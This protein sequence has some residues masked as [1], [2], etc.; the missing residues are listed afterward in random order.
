MSVKLGLLLINCCC[1]FS[2]DFLI[3]KLLL[4]SVLFTKKSVFFSLVEQPN[5]SRELE[6]ALNSL[7]LVK[8][9]ANG[10][11]RSY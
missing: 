5:F 2:F 7:S 11:K 8:C 1:L 10:V 3:A 6:K 9:L 4:D